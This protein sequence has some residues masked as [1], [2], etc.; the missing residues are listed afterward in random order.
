MGTLRTEGFSKS[1]AS[2]ILPLPAQ[3]KMGLE[4]AL[5]LLSLNGVELR[6]DKIL[7]F[8]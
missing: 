8:W 5:F 3:V 7:K 4:R 1:E 6:L 2:E